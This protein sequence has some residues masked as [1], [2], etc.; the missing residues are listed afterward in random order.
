MLSFK[1]FINNFISEHFL[2]EELSPAQEKIVN[3]WTNRMKKPPAGP[4][5]SSHLPFD[6]KGRMDIDVEKSN[7]PPIE[8]KEHVSPEVADHLKSKGY[9]AISSTHAQDESGK[10]TQRIGKLLGDNPELQRKHAQS[11][12]GTAKGGNYKIEIRRDPKGVAEMSSGNKQS[13]GTDIWTSCMKIADKDSPNFDD[14]VGGQHHLLVKQDIRHGTHI[15]YLHRNGKRIGRIALKPFVSPSGHTILRPEP[16]VYGSQDENGD[17]QKTVSAWAEH[18][19]PMKDSESHYKIHPD[20]YDDANLNAPGKPGPRT[21]LFN[22]NLSGERLHHLIKTGDSNTISQA[23]KNHSNVGVDHLEAALA[24]PDIEVQKAAL[25]H[26]KTPAHHIEKAIN[27]WDF[28]KQEAALRNPKASKES[29]SKVLQNKNGQYTD[30]PRAVALRH[31]TATES[32]IEGIIAH[33]KSSRYLQTAAANRLEEI[34]KEKKE[35]AKETAAKIMA[36]RNN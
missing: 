7:T 14:Q 27:S 36:M 24:H 17:F 10:R 4:Q 18:H 19:F 9:T 5:I 3:G 35:K 33:P 6:E 2:F 31:P 16:K 21:V 29:V 28:R 1:Q 34:L 26:E 22:P 8:N 20:L 15:A 23:I 11:G 32:D 12:V 13:D 30:E 25:G